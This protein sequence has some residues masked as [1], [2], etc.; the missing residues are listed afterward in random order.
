MELHILTILWQSQ[1]LILFLGFVWRHFPSSSLH[2]PCTPPHRN[3]IHQDIF[4]NQSICL[5]L[6]VGILLNKTENSKVAKSNF[7]KG[8]GGCVQCNL[9]KVSYGVRTSSPLPKIAFRYFIIVLLLIMKS[10]ASI[11][12]NSN[13]YIELTFSKFLYSS[14]AE[15]SLIPEQYWSSPSKDSV[16]SL[17]IVWS[18]ISSSQSV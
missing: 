7:W 13:F 2:S 18:I 11:K 14:F 1:W 3:H 9:P 4:P 8:A 10:Q 17:M 5:T 6:M 12:M 15:H 16:H